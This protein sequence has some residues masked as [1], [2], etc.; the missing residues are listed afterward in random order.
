MRRA[1][2]LAASA[3][4]L[5]LSPGCCA[6][7]DRPTGLRAELE[8]VLAEMEA[9][10]RS[11]DTTALKAVLSS[12]R[13]AD[14]HN[15]AVSR[16]L[17]FDANT[18]KEMG[19]DPLGLDDYRFVKLLENG[20][21]AGLVYVRDEPGGRGPQ[22]KPG[23]VFLVCRFV[24]ESGGGK[25]GS[26]RW[27][28]DSIGLM[29]A[30][31]YAEDG[32]EADYVPTKHMPEVAIDGVVRK[33][34]PL[35]PMPDYRGKVSRMCYGYEVTLTINGILQHLSGGGGGEGQLVGGLR[36]GENRVRIE[37]A[38]VKGAPS[39]KL[40]VEILVPLPGDKWK[41]VFEYKPAKGKA[42]AVHEAVIAMPPP[43]AE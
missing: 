17:P 10:Y 8:G 30:N 39:R 42:A 15:M 33:A 41:K 27:R 43:K 23:V 31:K 37:T 7:K 11:G 28:S 20:D 34:P 6:K 36:A 12:Y 26:I 9:A 18:I 4:I 29:H 16:L 13:Y 38:P 21:T 2:G 19:A 1:L 40:E 25:S 14:M 24:R 5:L 35:C 32:T 22:K 3:F